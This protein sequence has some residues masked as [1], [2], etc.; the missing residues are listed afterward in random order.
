MRLSEFFAVASRQCRP[1]IVILSHDGPPSLFDL[2]PK[3]RSCDVNTYDEL[4][5]P[6]HLDLFVPCLS[7]PVITQG[8]KG[9]GASQLKDCSSSC[10]RACYLPVE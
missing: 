2:L 7:R 6:I 4:F 9:K 3:A 5:I 1:A 8:S 10:R